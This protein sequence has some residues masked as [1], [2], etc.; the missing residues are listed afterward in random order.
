M[1]PLVFDPHQDHPERIVPVDGHRQ[2]QGADRL[3]HNPADGVTIGLD[4][5]ERRPVVMRG[6]QVVPRHL[7]DAHGEHR[8]E[9]GIDA[10]GRNLGDDQ[11][12]DVESCRMPEIEDQ[13]VPQRF[14]PQIECLLRGQGFVKLLVQA[15]GGVEIPPDFLALFLG[16]TLIE[17]RGSRVS[18]VHGSLTPVRPMPLPRRSRRIGRAWSNSGLPALRRLSP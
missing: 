6:V 11:L 9:A 4:F 13:G 15:V 16:L 8:F 2:G 10:P 1:D 7:V 18:Q 3:V 17:D 12:V 14:R 5:V